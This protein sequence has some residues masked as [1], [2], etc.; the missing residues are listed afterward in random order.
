VSIEFWGT[1]KPHLSHS[2][3]TKMKKKKINMENVDRMFGHNR[4]TFLFLL[5]STNLFIICLNMIID[6]VF[7]VQ[8]FQW[9]QNYPFVVGDCLFDLIS[10]LLHY[11]Q[12]SPQF[13]S[14]CMAHFAQSLQWPT[15]AFQ[16]IINI[17]FD[18]SLIYKDHGIHSLQTYVDKMT[19]SAKYGGLWGDNHAKFCLENYSWISIYVRSKKNCVICLHVDDD[20]I[21]NS[22][23]Q[24][25]YHDEVL[26]LT[27]NNYELIIF[28]NI[29]RLDDQKMLELAFMEHDTKPITQCFNMGKNSLCLCL[30]LMMLCTHKKNKIQTSHEH[31]H[32]PKHF[33]WQP[34]HDNYE[35]EHLMSTCP[36]SI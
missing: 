4:S 19:I 30:T 18:V 3:T 31:V 22:P 33:R 2:P 13:C 12:T 26:N 34:I 15:H 32:K 10:I 14:Q 11:S 8:Y 16:E 21:T 7:N 28:H 23:L 17:H 5:V 35:L 1:T 27:K 36:L 24:L 6:N 9:V 25:L 20:F 29:S